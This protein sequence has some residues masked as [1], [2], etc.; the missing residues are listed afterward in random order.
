MKSSNSISDVKK[1]LELEEKINNKIG[2]INILI[3]QL[4]TQYKTIESKAQEKLDKEAAISLDR[5]D[6]GIKQTNRAAIEEDISCKQDDLERVR[7]NLFAKYRLKREI[8]DLE[9]NDLKEVNGQIVKI[10]TRIRKNLCS[11]D[12][13]TRG[14]ETVYLPNYELHL[15]RL[16]NAVREYST[17][18]DK[19]NYVTMGK[20]PEI[21]PSDFLSD[22]KGMFGLTVVK[23]VEFKDIKLGT[24]SGRT[25]KEVLQDYEESME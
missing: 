19:V 3:S 15:R 20:L 13:T 9:E 10:Q 11:I 2:A 4:N 7:L 6:L 1:F 12:E 21:K 22:K 23:N 16:E 18:V 24:T 25:L 5:E 8:K 17:I 14:L